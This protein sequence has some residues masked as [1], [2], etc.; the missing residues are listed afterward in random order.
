MEQT[1]TPNLRAV[2]AGVLEEVLEEG[3]PLK[4]VLQ[5]A[6]ARF[7]R[8]DDRAL[9]REITAG[10]MRRLPHID[11]A[12]E[13]L[14]QRGLAETQSELLHILRVGAYQILF[15]ER[16]PAYAAVSECVNA[17]KGL[18]PGAGG[19]VN[20]IL[21]ALAQRR[22]D[23]LD[24][25]LRFGGEEGASLRLGMPPWLFERYCRR[26]GEEEAENLV[27]SLNEA[28]PTC[29]TFLSPAAMAQGM[30]LLSREGFALKQDPFI[31][32]AFSVE[33]GNP[34]E[35]EAFRRGLFYI[36]DPASQAP[37][38][39]LPLKGG[40][41]V[42]DLCAAPGGKTALL[43]AS[44]SKGGWVL[45]V[46][47]SIARLKMLKDN[48][49][50]LG[51]ANARVVQADVGAPLPFTSGWAAV[52]LDAPCSSLGTLRRNPEIRWQI[53]E[54][55]LARK[56]QKQSDFLEEAARMVG[57]GGILAYSVCS[58]EE[59]ETVEVVRRFLDGHEDFKPLAPKAP[60]AWKESL[61]KAGDG[62]CLLP[63]RRSWD[64]FFVALFKRGKR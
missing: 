62:F 12:L 20:G 47:R 43:S 48:V 63:H 51:L 21:R 30:P 11:L 44:L 18:N 56:S 64:A 10:V 8:E 45:A 61:T 33:H 5:K 29:L 25:P 49:A 35:S 17:A 39:L 26:F 9:L 16:V 31:P 24:A 28:A 2:A 19:F 22:E 58:I 46:D 3:R 34:S 13:E 60:A 7:P 57:P 32:L 42:L 41:A 15:M 14:T 23:L 55:D 36:M 4:A 37:A 27:R 50:R 54:E 53:T 59:E 38:V 1:P 6:Q 40:E 52:L